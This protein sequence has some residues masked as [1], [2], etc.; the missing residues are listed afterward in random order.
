M[1]VPLS[2]THRTLSVILTAWLA[3]S[4]ALSCHRVSVQLMT[5][6]GWWPFITACLSQKLQQSL[7]EVRGVCVCVHV[8]VHAWVCGFAEFM[9]NSVG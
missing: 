1:R 6:T 5:I 2:S 4:H 9:K 3:S 7:R 8:C